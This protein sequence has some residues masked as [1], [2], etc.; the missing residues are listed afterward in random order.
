TPYTPAQM[1]SGGAPASSPQYDPTVAA[2]R[3][4]DPTVAAPPPYAGQGFQPPVNPTPAQPAYNDYNR[5]PANPYAPQ[6]PSP[7]N[8]APGG[9]NAQAGYGTPPPPP[10]AYAPPY[11]PP[12][13]AFVPPNQPPQKKG[14]NVGLI[15]GIVALLIV[16]IGGG[17]LAIKAFSHP[18]GQTNSPTPGASSTT[19]ATTPASSPTTAVTAS[20]ATNQGPSPSGSPID[21]TAASIITNVQTASA[22]DSNYL[23]THTTN[24]FSVG[25]V[26]YVTFHLNLTASGYVQAKVYADNVYVTQSSLTVTVGKYDHGYFQITY[27]KASAGAFELYW[28]LQ[29]DC[30]DAALAAVASFTVS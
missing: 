2:P 12:P 4:Y 27:N 8:N 22:I 29:S 15:I 11:A 21:T 1:A 13:G 19:N 5:Q 10:N 23:P 3:P 24:Q 6:P 28:C 20:P 16:L 14:P 30:S 26:V 25:N 18:Q 17:L 9:Y 7:F